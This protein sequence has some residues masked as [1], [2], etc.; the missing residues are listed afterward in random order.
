MKVLFVIGCVIFMAVFAVAGV[1]LT[2][3]SSKIS[4]EEEREDTQIRYNTRRKSH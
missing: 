1:A 2:M 4:Q 3:F